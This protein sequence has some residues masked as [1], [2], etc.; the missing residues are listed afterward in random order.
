MALNAPSGGGDWAHE[1]VPLLETEE[2]T[3]LTAWAEGVSEAAAGR[4]TGRRL[5]VRRTPHG[6]RRGSS[7]RGTTRRIGSAGLALD[8]RGTTHQTTISS[9]QHRLSQWPDAEKCM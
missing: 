3:V 4:G 6:R 8:G 7:R 1:V 2:L 5:A 9:E